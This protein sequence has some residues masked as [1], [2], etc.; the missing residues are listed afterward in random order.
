[1]TIYTDGACSSKDNLGGWACVDTERGENYF[2]YEENSTNNRMELTAVIKALELIRAADDKI[3]T[4]YTDSAYVSNCFA[5]KWYITWRR[6]GWRNSS[7]QAVKNR[8]LWERLLALYE[9]IQARSGVLL[10]I[11]KVNGHAGNEYNEI[12]DKLAVKARQSKRKKDINGE[13]N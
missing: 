9:E 8:E 5:Q 7:K 2:G 1:M 11:V 6:N 13:T 10:T 3:N 4:V 12:C